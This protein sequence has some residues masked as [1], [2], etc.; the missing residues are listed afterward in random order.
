MST[1]TMDPIVQQTFESTPVGYVLSL[2]LGGG[3]TAAVW[4]YLAKRRESDAD[5]LARF[6]TRLDARLASVE[7]DRDRLLL[8]LGDVNI[9]LAVAQTQISD[10]ASE[11]D[12]LLGVVGQLREQNKILRGRLRQLG[13]EVSEADDSPSGAQKVGP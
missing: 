8:Q 4:A 7:Q 3:G 2:V 1:D 9:K 11:R 10:L 5:R 6:E 13:E 12:A